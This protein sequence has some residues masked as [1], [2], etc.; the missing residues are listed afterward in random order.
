MRVRARV[1]GVLRELLALPAHAASAFASRIKVMADM[2]ISVKRRPQDGR[3]AVR[4]DGRDLALRVS[5]LPAQDGEKIVIRILESGGRAPDFDAIGFDAR[6]RSRF[7]RLLERS[8]GVILVTGP[9]GSG[10]TTTLYSALGRLDRERRNILTLE[11]PIE[12]RLDGLTQVQVHRKAGLGFAAGLRA[13]LRQDPDVIMVGE[14]RDRETAEIAMAAAMTGHLVLSTIHTNDAPSAASRLMEMGTPAY[15]IAA[16]LIGV[17]AQRLARRLCEHCAIRRAA[18]PEELRAAG[19]P[20]DSATLFAARGCRRCDDTG[21]HGRIGIFELLAVDARVRRLLTRKAPVDAIRDAARHQGMRTLAQ[22]AWDKVRAG[23]TTL[24]EVRP[25][26]GGLADDAP[27]CRHCGAAIR[28]AFRTCP[29][30]TRPLRR[31]C[32]CGT[33]LDLHW[34]CCPRCGRE[35]SDAQPALVPKLTSGEPVE[36]PCPERGTLKL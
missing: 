33:A 11:D 35:T 27:T 19:L 28:P 1:D 26:L 23:W 20:A 13:A 16:G 3:A 4:V 6:T 21:Y 25:L 32:A 2:D 22:D 10:K 17:L 7:T 24:D 29:H 14:L 15:L 5:T 12:Y 18:R 9:T 34:R 31:S 36:N 8:H 30:C